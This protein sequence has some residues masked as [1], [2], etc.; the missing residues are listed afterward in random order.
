MLYK[1]VVNFTIVVLEFT[2]QTSGT[3]SIPDNVW[4]KI[5]LFYSLSHWNYQKAKLESMKHLA[6]L[7]DKT[8]YVL[9]SSTWVCHCGYM[10]AIDF[11]DA[12]VAPYG[13]RR[14]IFYLNNKTYTYDK[15]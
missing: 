10:L 4:E 7:L 9:L 5:S 3:N 11:M 1:L 12:N 6:F 15:I 13:R 8:S 14:L 2:P